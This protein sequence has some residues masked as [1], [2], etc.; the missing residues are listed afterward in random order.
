MNRF[1]HLLRSGLWG[2]PANPELFA[3]MKRAEWERLYETAS[4]QAVLGVVYD[5]LSTLPAELQPERT[6]LLQ[7][8]MQVVRIENNNRKINQA[9]TRFDSEMRSLGIEYMLLK[10]PGVA[11]FYPNP[12][13][14]QTGDIDIFLLTP[15]ADR[16]ANLWA[17]VE[18]SEH[19][20]SVKHTG[21]RWNDVSYELHHRTD[22]LHNPFVCHKA[23]LHRRQCAAESGP[24]T[25]SINGHDIATLAPEANFFYMMMHIFSHLM[26]G[27]IGL[28]QFCDCALYIAAHEGQFDNQRLQALFQSVGLTRF[29][30]AFAA[31]LTDYLDLA[32][33][34]I[35]YA[36][37]SDELA[38][39]MLRDIMAGGN[40]GAYHHR[41]RAPR[42]KW[43]HK[44]H[45]TRIILK[46]CLRFSG[47][48][49]R[50]A[51]WLPAYYVVRNVQLLVR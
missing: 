26:T 30:D 46:R 1:F 4:Q 22:D 35:P 11:T 44:L 2:Y 19:S 15:E 24:T 32:P 21:F 12:L 5:G 17:E 31:I 29:A 18:G 49:L 16:A 42:G 33:N 40:F 7:W 9:I 8:F 27:G 10:G 36:Y 14:R 25:V 28:R 6:L 48:G 37:Q 45:T 38:E 50:E 23:E 34:L 20:V 51:A 41:G 13:H 3:G 47:L 39:E 43:L